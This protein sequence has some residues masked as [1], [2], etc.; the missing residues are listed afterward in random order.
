MKNP[1]PPGKKLVKRLSF[2]A[3]YLILTSVSILLI[4]S[5]LA[6]LCE[7][8][9][10]RYDKEPFLRWFLT[11]TYAYILVMTGVL[12]LQN[13][14]RYRILIDARKISRREIK[15]AKMGVRKVVVRKAVE[16]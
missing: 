15:R 13:A 14:T 2:R 11:G 6:I 9:I 3:K 4:G 16:E 12:L 1:K 8:A 10:M 7:A 5:G